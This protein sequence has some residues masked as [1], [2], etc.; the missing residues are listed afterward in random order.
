MSRRAL[1][2]KEPYV[3]ACMLAAYCAGS[4][5]ADIAKAF[6]RN[7][8]LIVRTA[9]ENNWEMQRGLFRKRLER[10]AKTEAEAEL[11]ENLKILQNIRNAQWNEIAKRIGADGKKGT[12]GLPV[13]QQVETLVTVIREQMR[14]FGFGEKDTLGGGGVLIQAENVAIV[15][16]MPAAERRAVK[17]KLLEDL[18]MTDPVEAEVVEEGEC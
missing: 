17:S 2:D 9:S 5:P 14:L 12:L 8:S 7:R 6:S 4:C 1:K 11:A 18:G 10:K 16:G 15:M 13:S 3:Y